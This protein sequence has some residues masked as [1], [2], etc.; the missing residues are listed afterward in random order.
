MVCLRWLRKNDP[1]CVN[2]IPLTSINMASLL[3]LNLTLVVIP[4]IP[5]VCSVDHWWSARLAQVILQS[6]YKS[7]FCAS[8]CIKLK[9]SAHKK[10]LGTIVLHTLD[11]NKIITN[12]WYMKL[13][14][15]I[16][17]ISLCNAV[18]SNLVAIR[19]M[20]RQDL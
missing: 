9:W 15:N 4:V 3:E 19:L 7:I 17:A 16:K 12:L 11:L 6:L 2:T 1:T 13:L 14:S 5:K 8:R 20:W 18:V 10:S